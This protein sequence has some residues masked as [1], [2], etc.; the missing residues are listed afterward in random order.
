[1]F[2][3]IPGMRV[4]QRTNERDEYAS[5]L[6]HAST[7]SA[8]IL[9][10][11]AVV[12][13]IALTLV[14]RGLVYAIALFIAAR[15][16]FPW[17]ASAPGA[18]WRYYARLAFVVGALLALAIAS[19]YWGQ[20]WPP[21]WYRVT[22]T[23]QPVS[24]Y[25]EVGF[26]FVRDSAHWLRLPAFVAFARGIIAVAAIM[27]WVVPAFIVARRNIQSAQW[28]FLDAIQPKDYEPYSL[29]GHGTLLDKLFNLSTSRSDRDARRGDAHARAVVEVSSNSGRVI[30][31]TDA[32]IG[33]DEL[34]RFVEYAARGG[35]LSER[36]VV[37]ARV[38][39]Q[40]KWRDFVAYMVDNGLA[41]WQ[42]ESHRTG[43][44]LNFNPAEVRFYE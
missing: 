1:M 21:V 16:G 10:T 43:I 8:I 23:E 15:Y 42:D 3:F 37:G 38:M 5:M 24:C 9:T 40:K 36:S 31:V 7:L 27:S 44:R 34:R 6:T 30:R 2:G 20:V 33:A 28:P 19:P 25:N 32:P 4:S 39:S 41:E 22:C 18:I 11:F 35:A 17:A 14:G 13:P 26:G 29:T 12:L